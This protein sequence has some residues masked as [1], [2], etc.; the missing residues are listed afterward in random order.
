[1]GYR[2]YFAIA[3]LATVLANLANVEAFR[4]I[5]GGRDERL[6][7]TLI[8]IPGQSRGTTGFAADKL[9]MTINT[10]SE[11]LPYPIATEPERI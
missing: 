4:R 11:T 6:C 9:K 2:W 5:T 1:M 10:K 8:G 7:L 3:E